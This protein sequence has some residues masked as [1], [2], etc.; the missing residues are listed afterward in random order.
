M[1]PVQAPYLCHPLPP[2]DGSP[3]LRVLRGDPTPHG[4]SA[5]LSMLG[6]AY[7]CPGIHGVSHVLNASLSACQALRTPTDP[8]SLSPGRDLC[9]GFQCVQTVAICIDRFDEA[10]PD[11]RVC[12][13]P[14][15]LQSSLCTLHMFCSV[16]GTSSTHATLGTSGWLILTRW[17]LAPH[18]KRQA[19]LGALTLAVSRTTSRSEAVG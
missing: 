4:P 9:I 8:P 16:L 6:C 14:S 11:F 13:H 3:V 12:G 17:G 5:A 2:V 15:G 10:V 1:F 18:K 19:S 7:L